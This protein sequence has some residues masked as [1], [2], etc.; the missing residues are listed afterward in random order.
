MQIEE[1]NKGFG[2]RVSGFTP[3]MLDDQDARARLRSLFDERGAIVFPAL[4]IDFAQQERLC[5]TLIGDDRIAAGSSQRNPFYVSNKEEDAFAPYGRLMF[6]ADMMWH[7]QP[8]RALSLYAMTVEPG[9]ATTTLTSGVHAWASLSP[10]MRAKL[11]NLKAIHITGQVY[12]RGGDDLLRPGRTQEQETVKPLAYVHPNTGKPILL[13]SEQMTRE[14]VGMPG[15]AS[16]ALLQ[17]LFAH[18]YA[19]DMVYEHHWQK[20]DLLVFDNIAM[21]HA[22][23]NVPADG[24]TR[25]LRKVIAPIPDIA[26]ERPK[27]DKTN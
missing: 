17:E 9:S 24:P 7:P 23:G 8:F 4:D 6:H 21:Q 25:T 12:H 13:A 10:E 26:A 18:L 16:E 14:I 19:P 3:A 15:D 20:G 5:R 11:Q 27:Y 1:L 22:R 2:S